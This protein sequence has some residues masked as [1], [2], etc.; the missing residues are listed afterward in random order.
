MTQ[1]STSIVAV[2]S[3]AV[4]CFTAQGAA[5]QSE[6]VTDEAAAVP[7][8]DTS[9]EA[10]TEVAPASE[11]APEEPATSS[12]IMATPAAA[13]TVM[14]TAAPAAEEDDD[15]D[16]DSAGPVDKKPRISGVMQASARATYYD[17]TAQPDGTPLDDQYQFQIEHTHIK[18]SG[19][20]TEKLAWEIMPCVTHM[21]DFSVILANFTYALSSAGQITAGRFLL[22]FGQFNVRSLPGS[23]TTVSR[24]LLYQSHEDR[25]I[26]FGDNT[27]KSLYFTPRDDTGLMLGGSYWMGSDDAIQLSYSIYV[28][29]GLRAASNTMARFWDDNN[30]SK[31]YGGRLSASYNGNK[32]SA[33]FGG[34]FLTNKY[35]D[36]SDTRDGL[37]QRAWA[38]DGVV[39]YNWAPGRRVSVRGEYVDMERDIIPNDELIQGDEGLTGAY[40]IVEA[41]VLEYLAVYYAWDTL[42]QRTP[43]SQLNEG[44]RDVE[45]TTNRHIGGL[46]LTL[47]EALIVRAEYGRWLEPQGVSNANRVSIQTI[48]AF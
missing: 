21:N 34:S 39:S 24:P 4:L 20:L 45:T 7:A 11:A 44:F 23:Y 10:S 13:P 3:G 47:A 43:R 15:D 48:V 31:Q 36:H 22:P 28:T 26:L 37:D 35:E 38:V 29:N 8:A 32:L 40:V 18:F 42:S 25:M 6:G 12:E 17:R 2:L 9:V 19:D 5:A 30:S 16:W 41:D 14:P 46:S 1:R 33:T 27:P